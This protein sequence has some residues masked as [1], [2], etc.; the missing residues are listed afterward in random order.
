MTKKH[1]KKPVA[2]GGFFWPYGRGMAFYHNKFIGC[3]KRSALTSLNFLFIP[4]SLEIYLYQSIF[5]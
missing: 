5:S 3:A 4:L 1:E 2:A